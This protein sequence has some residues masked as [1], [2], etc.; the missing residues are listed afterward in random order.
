M[1]FLP[2]TAL[3]LWSAVTRELIRDPARDLS[4]RQMAVL[5][6]VYLDPETPTVRGLAAKLGLAKPAVTRALDRLEALD[7][8]RRRQDE[9]DRRSIVVQRTVKGS[10]FLADFAELAARTARALADSAL[11]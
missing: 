3:H 9:K 6:A 5:L 2:R 1:P 7:F 4:A 10:V 11:N 8:V